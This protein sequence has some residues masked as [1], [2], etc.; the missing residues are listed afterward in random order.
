MHKY[1]TL[2]FNGFSFTIVCERLWKNYSTI[3]FHPSQGKNTLVFTQSLAAPHRHT[4]NK[5]LWP[6]IPLLSDTW[7]PGGSPDVAG[8]RQGSTLGKSPVHHR[9]AQNAT[10]CKSLNDFT[11]ATRNIAIIPEW[12]QMRVH[13]AFG[14]NTI[15]MSS[16]HYATPT[17]TASISRGL[18]Y[19]F[20]PC[21]MIMILQARILADTD[22]DPMWYQ[23][24]STYFYDLFCSVEC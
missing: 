8:W 6:L 3:L 1:A 19:N 13:S 12:H 7:G 10:K 17:A 11:L 14:P 20:F 18:R 4:S 24:A 5:Y 2:E 16:F 21:D 15:N 22:M 23:P 9:A